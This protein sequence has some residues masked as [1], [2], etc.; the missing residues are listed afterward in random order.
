MEVIKLTIDLVKP[1]ENAYLK[2]S[3]KKEFH[4]WCLKRDL[5]HT[6]TII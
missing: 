2:V 4:E 3:A 1:I 5:P 6:N